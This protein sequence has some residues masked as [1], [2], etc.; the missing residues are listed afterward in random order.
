MNN[1]LITE[2]EVSKDYIA[3]FYENLYKAR[4][5]TPVYEEWTNHIKNKVREIDQSD[6]GEEPDFTMEE[7][8]KVIKSLKRAKSNGPDD[9]PNEIYIYR[10]LL[11]NQEHTS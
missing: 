4:D 11:N 1:N 2:P 6:P 7:L 10:K 3:N 8:N 9:I 5:V